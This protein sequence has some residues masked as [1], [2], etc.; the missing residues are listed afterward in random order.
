MIAACTDNNRGT[1]EQ[2][3]TGSEMYISMFLRL[4]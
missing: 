2:L 1:E 3:T 4:F